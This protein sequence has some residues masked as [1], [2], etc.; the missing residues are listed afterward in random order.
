VDTQNIRS[1]ALPK[2]ILI[3]ED[4]TVI[5]ELLAA[6]LEEDGYNVEA[7]PNGRDALA[8][9]SDFDFDLIL[10]DVMMPYTTGVEMCRI[11]QTDDHYANRS[12]IPVVLMSTGDIT[13]EEDGCRIAAFIPKPFDIGLVL[14][15]IQDAL[16]YAQ[17]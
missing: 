11:I 4:E 8:R 3:V 15:T 14:S 2:S 1:T 13:A 10:S 6:V 9:I 12:K 5:A 17:C 16:K 7:V